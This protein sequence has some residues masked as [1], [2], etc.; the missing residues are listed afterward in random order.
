MPQ[1]VSVQIYLSTELDTAARAAAKRA[2][3]TLSGWVRQCIDNALD[4]SDERPLARIERDLVFATV[5]LDALLLAHD[6]DRL[7]DRTLKAFHR[8][9]ERRSALNPML[10]SDA[11]EA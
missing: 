10:G 8:K 5:A 9:L 3:D 1:R 6:D 7:R 4:A 2:G 11:R